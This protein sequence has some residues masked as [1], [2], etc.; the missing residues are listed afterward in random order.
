MKDKN[1]A[2]YDVVAKATGNEPSLHEGSPDERSRIS[3]LRA[4][5]GAKGGKRAAET[6]SAEARRN[7]AKLGG[8]ARWT[9]EETT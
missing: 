5:V 7:R 6:M 4:E 9:K 8:D 1:Q 3:I 2:A